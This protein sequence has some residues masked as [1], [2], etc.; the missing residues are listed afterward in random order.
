MDTL[1][2]FAMGEASRGK[3]MRCFDWDKAAEIIR[4]RRPDSAA[5]GLAEDLEWTSGEI[6]RDGSPVPAD[7]TYVYLAS[8]WATP[9]LIL[10]GAEIECWR[11]HS[12][13]PAEWGKPENS[14]WPESALAIAFPDGKSKPKLSAHVTEKE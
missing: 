5:A 9:V 12:Q 10:S 14:Y 8:T 13:V 3:E 4:D 2:A 7:D 6:L 1:S 11:M